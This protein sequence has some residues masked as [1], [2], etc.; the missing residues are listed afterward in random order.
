MAPRQFY[1]AVGT[2]EAK[3]VRRDVGGCAGAGPASGDRA[4]AVRAA[5]APPPTPA[6]TAAAPPPL[7]PP[8]PAPADQTTLVELLQALQ[9][10]GAAPP[11]GAPVAVAC[12]SRDALDSVVAALAARGTF[13]LAV[14]VRA[15]PR[16]RRLGV[17]GSP[18]A[19][20]AGR[21]VRGRAPPDTAPP[22]LPIPPPP[23]PAL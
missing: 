2:Q 15:G 3:L 11:V 12:G 5:C 1:V 4:R 7:P 8:P 16:P 10:E 18:A 22:L 9:S 14:L 19:G 21:C 13:A 6:L 23:A 17:T 20:R